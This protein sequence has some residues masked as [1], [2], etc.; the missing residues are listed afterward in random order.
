[1]FLIKA[2]LSMC[3]ENSQSVGVTF[4]SDSKDFSI[5]TSQSI[6]ILILQQPVVYEPPLDKTNKEACAPSETQIS[7]GIRP[8]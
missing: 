7:L 6:K 1:M 5:C 2:K 8:D 3:F 4:A